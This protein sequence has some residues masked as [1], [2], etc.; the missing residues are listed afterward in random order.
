MAEPFRL[1]L[2]GAGLITQGSHLPAALASDRVTVSALVDSVPGR[3]E[4]LA[5]NYGIKPIVTTSMREILGQID[6][7]LIA[8]PN[9]SHAAIAVECLHAGVSVLIEKPLAATAAE[10]EE[11]LAAAKRSGATVAVGYSTRFRH[12]TDFLKALL[13]RRYFGAVRRFVHQFGTPGGW[14]PLSAYN[15]DRK[16]AGGGVVVV[17]G[18]HFLDRMLYLWGMPTEVSLEDDAHGGPEANGTVSFRFGDRPDALTGIARYSKTTRLPAG[19]AIDCERG[20]VTLGDFDDAEIVFEPND[21]SGVTQVLRAGR[22]PAPVPDS[23][24]LQIEDFVDACRDRR[25]PRVSGEQGVQ[26]LRLIERMYANRRNFSEDWYAV[27]TPPPAG[28]APARE[29]RGVA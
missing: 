11:I 20:V 1:A 14:A 22:A 5:R 29:L 6:G 24:R 25:P 12:S 28:A 18:T 19:L 17:T 27:A 26:S 23:F 15:L 10:G 4:S 8:T 7:A 21:G 9:D 2:V 13:E 3:A 16:T